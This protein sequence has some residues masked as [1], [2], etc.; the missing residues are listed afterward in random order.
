MHFASGWSFYSGVILLIISSGLLYVPVEIIKL[1]VSRLLAIAGFVGILLSSCP[2][3]LWLLIALTLAVVF[4]FVVKN[5]LY[6]YVSTFLVLLFIAAALFFEIPYWIAPE[7][8]NLKSKNVYVIADSISAGIGFKGEKT[9]PKLLGEQYGLKVINKSVGGG[10][11]AT[12]DKSLM[13]IF[14]DKHDLI[15]IEI[16]GNDVLAGVSGSVFRND[17]DKLL[18]H[19]TSKAQVIMFEIPLPPFCGRIAEAQRALAAEYGVLLIPKRF[20]SKVLEG[21][22]STVDGLHLSNRGHRKMARTAAS[23]IVLSK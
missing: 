19:A 1:Y 15:I 20:F 2:L 3:P 10:R 22:E 21:K 8:L 9:W 6:R 23:F 11:V 18:R 4:Q 12:A 5:K 14:P 16:G 17:L 13:K 7:P